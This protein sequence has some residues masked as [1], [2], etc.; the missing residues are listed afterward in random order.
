MSGTQIDFNASA[1]YELVANY[2]VL[3][4][5]FNKLQIDKVTPALQWLHR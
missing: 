3:Q 5:C 2:K 1:D 4:D